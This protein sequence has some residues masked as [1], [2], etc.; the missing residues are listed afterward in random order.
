MVSGRTARS[1]TLW[2]LAATI[3]FCV[4][5]GPFGLEPVMQ[6]GLWLG[7][8]LILVV[9]IV[10]ALPSALMTA[11][12]ASAL[13]E[14][15]GYYVWVLQALGP[16]PGFLCAWWSWVYS[17]LDAAIYPTLFFAYLNNLFSLLHGTA[18][19][20]VAPWLKW[21]VGLVL[22]VPL[23]ALNIRGIRPVGRTALVFGALLLLPFLA[24]IAMGLPYAI[25]HPP[26]GFV[27]PGKGAGEA[28]GAGLFVVMWNYL[29]W[30][31]MSTV[32]GEV[33]EPRRSFPRALALCGPLIVASYALPVFVG[34]ARVTDP[35]KWAEGSW[36]TTAAVIGGT[37]L[38][39]AMTIAGVF[40][41]A[42]QFGSV[43]LS[44]SRVPFA[45]AEH[46]YLP[47]ALSKLSRR[48]GTPVMAILISVLFTTI[49]SYESF[50][51]LAEADVIL[52]SCGLVL[53]FVALVV[54]KVKEPSLPRPYR[55]S[56]GLPV[57]VAV[58]LMPIVLI[59]FAT[60]N[61]FQTA[62]KAGLMASGLGILSAFVAYPV[63]RANR[64]G[65]G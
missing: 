31:S 22:I 57:A 35:A 28:V 43:L 44:G 50:K 12:L 40:S 7:M 59:V 39:V 52:Y 54:L 45:L 15:G 9:P 24:L 53:E 1:L 60:I 10:W 26:H 20:E 8:T 58:V 19:T 63:C 2:P 16:F 41:T 49:L 51:D 21:L 18:G 29:G 32:A 13:P 17:W 6:G 25:S 27:A 47:L 30:D 5:G 62:E 64:P 55:I 14:E 11:E 36:T 37:W 61:Q 3:F 56:G 46:G 33:S 65:V 4:S 48:F 34:M 23:T 38:A 42:G